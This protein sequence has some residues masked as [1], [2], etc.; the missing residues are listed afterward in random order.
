MVINLVVN[1]IQMILLENR[2]Y[3]RILIVWKK[4][5]IWRPSAVDI[6][7]PWKYQRWDQA[8]RKKPSSITFYKRYKTRNQGHGKNWNYKDNEE[9]IQSEYEPKEV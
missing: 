4:S 1:K 6:S 9:N 2:K 7:N 3:P 8:L 5:S